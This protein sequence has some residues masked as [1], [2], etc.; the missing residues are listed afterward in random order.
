MKSNLKYRQ[1]HLQAFPTFEKMQ[2]KHDIY[3]FK[4]THDIKNVTTLY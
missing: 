3:I 4:L 1:R 2:A